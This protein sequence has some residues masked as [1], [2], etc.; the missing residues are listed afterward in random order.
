MSGVDDHTVTGRVLAVLDAVAGL[1][2]EATLA[3]LARHTGIPKPTVRRIAADLV[4]RG[5]LERRA[6]G[7]HLGP[8]LLELGVRTATQNGLHR[9]ATPHIQDLFARTGEIVWISALTETANLLLNAAFGPDRAAD[10]RNPWPADIRSP[11]FLTTAA[12]RVLMTDRP[13]LADDLRRRPLPRLTPYTPTTWRSVMADV[14]AIADNGVAVEA[15]QSRRGYSCVAAGIRGPGGRIVG[16]LGVVGRTDSF[17]AH[18]LTRPVL[19]AV[20]DIQRTL[21]GP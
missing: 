11:G 19:A 17:V 5:V 3:A 18:R 8:R 1:P 20:T 7:Y 15:E 6:T 10:I 2:G 9:A 14:Q 13:E 21:S 12:G 4:A 16:V